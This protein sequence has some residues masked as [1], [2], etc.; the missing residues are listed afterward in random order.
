MIFLETVI[1]FNKLKRSKIL[2]LTKD[3]ILLQK[4]NWKEEMK[5]DNIVIKGIDQGIQLVNIYVIWKE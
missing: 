5:R 1:Q 4:L 3:N 2:V